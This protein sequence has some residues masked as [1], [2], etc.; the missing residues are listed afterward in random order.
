MHFREYLKLREDRDEVVRI[1][2]EVDWNLEASAVSALN[3]RN[4]G[5]KKVL[6]FE[7]IKGYTGFT[8]VS[9]LFSNPME[10][11]W[12]LYAEVQSLDRDISLDDYYSA[13]KAKLAQHVPPTRVSTGPCKENIIMGKNVNL[14]SIPFPYLHEGDGGRYGTLQTWIGKD[15]DSAW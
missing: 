1:K 6:M 12:S 14:F 5:Q 8:L 7:S 13:V 15:P 4:W 9:G 11:P 10:K 3:Y 2:Q